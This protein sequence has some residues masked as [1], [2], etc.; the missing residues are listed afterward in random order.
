MFV[1]LTLKLSGIAGHDFDGWKV[2]AVEFVT[3]TRKVVTVGSL[4]ADSLFSGFGLGAL[5]P[6]D[7]KV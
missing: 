7:P 2:F 4:S 6:I 5:S 3:R 1:R